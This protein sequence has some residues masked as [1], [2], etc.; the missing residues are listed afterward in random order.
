MFPE[1]ASLAR[2][3]TALGGELARASRSAMITSRRE[4]AC[5]SIGN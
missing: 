2:N 5:H 1:F 4:N 3:S